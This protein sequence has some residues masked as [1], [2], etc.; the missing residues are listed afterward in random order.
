ME[1]Q[2]PIGLKPLN[3]F[4]LSS[5]SSIKDCFYG[6]ETV[7][8]RDVFFHETVQIF[9]PLF[10]NREEERDLFTFCCKFM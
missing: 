4:T 7:L 10:G 2:S 1:Y 8:D 6:V 5:L 9:C 3:Q